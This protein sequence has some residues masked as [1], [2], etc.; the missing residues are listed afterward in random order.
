MKSILVLT[1][2]SLFVSG[3]AT[4]TFDERACPQEKKYTKA[5]QEQLANELEKAGPMINQAFVDYGKLRD[6]ARACR[7]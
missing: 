6:K 3:C 4:A 2:L 1:I 7:K 5:Q